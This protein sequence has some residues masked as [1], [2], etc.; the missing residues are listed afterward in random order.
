MEAP[1][2]LNWTDEQI[3]RFWD[4]QS[5]TETSQQTYFAFQVGEAVARI[6]EMAVDS[7]EGKKVLD[8]GSG[9]GH[10][11][12]HLLKQGAE[13]YATDYSP[14][15]IDEVTKRFVSHT[16]WGAAERFDG[17]RLPWEDNTFDFV[18]CLETIEHLHDDVCARI[19]AELHRVLRPSGYA[20][21]TTPHEEKLSDHNV[22]CPNCNCEFHRMQH[23]RSWA[24]DSLTTEL[25]R[26]EY[27]VEYCRGVDLHDF[28]PPRKWRGS[29]LRRYVKTWATSWLDRVFPRAFPNQRALNQA[30]RPRRQRNLV[31]IASK[32]AASQGVLP[33]ARAA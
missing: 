5:I 1:K 17:H 18:F 31:A 29:K 33:A 32:K 13:V 7:F 9:P 26:H 20:M 23:L 24:V 15:S 10:L 3:A 25:E 22:Y 4:Y 6:A 19:F 21:Y 27:E 12:P 2:K 11:I 30:V 28:Q 8:F 16:N 14:N